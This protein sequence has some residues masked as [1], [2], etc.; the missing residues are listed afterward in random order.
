MEKTESARHCSRFT[1]EEKWIIRLLAF[2]LV[3]F[4][5]AFFLLP[6]IDTN[7]WADLGAAVMGLGDFFNGTMWATSK[8]EQG[9]GILLVFSW[10]VGI[11]GLIHSLFFSTRPSRYFVFLSYLAEGIFFIG[12]SWLV[13]A[14][15]LGFTSLNDA[16]YGSSGNK[17]V[18]VIFLI[19]FILF[20]LTSFGLFGYCFLVVD[21][22]KEAADEAK[23]AEEVALKPIP[24]VELV[25]KEEPAKAIEQ[26]K[27]IVTPAAHEETTSVIAEPSPVIS[28]PSPIVAEPSEPSIQTPYVHPSIAFVSSTQGRGHKERCACLTLASSAYADSPTIVRLSRAE[29]ARSPLY[30]PSPL[31]KSSIRFNYGNEKAPMDSQLTQAAFF[32]QGKVYRANHQI[33]EEPAKKTRKPRIPFVEKLQSAAPELKANYAAVEALLA[34]YGMKPRSSIACDTYSL[35][36]V[37]YLKATIHGKNLKLFFKLDPK[38]YDG[39]TLPHHDAS[40]MGVYKDTPLSLRVKSPL[41][42]RRAEKLVETMMVQAG[43][44]AKAKKD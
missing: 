38:A 42:L 2:V 32:R 1:P 5:I 40:K 13:L 37:H 3:F 21:A 10:V 43:I 25:H 16:L 29:V 33:N 8:G 17:A 11:V 36:R 18:V 39:T 19:A 35:H 20:Y 31:R 14:S 30:Q 28:E 9:L 26:I 6:L 7:G 34:S 12:S 4:L 41:S 44:Q 22:N 24:V 15:Y 27:P 23:E